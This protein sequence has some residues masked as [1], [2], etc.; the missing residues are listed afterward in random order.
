ME[1]NFKIK[2]PKANS[3]IGMY[4]DEPVGMDHPIF[5]VRFQSR[6]DA[7]FCIQDGVPLKDAIQITLARMRDLF[8]DD[9][10]DEL[11]RTAVSLEYAECA[12]LQPMQLHLGV[13]VRLYH[14]EGGKV[15][16]AEF[17]KI[18]KGM[19]KAKAILL[20]DEFLKAVKPPD[21]EECMEIIGFNGRIEINV[22]K[23]ND[24]E[25]SKAK[26]PRIY[27]DG[28][29]IVT[30]ASISANATKEDLIVK[31]TEIAIRT[32]RRACVVWSESETIYAEPAKWHAKE[33]NKEGKKYPHITIFGQKDC[34]L[35]YPNTTEEELIV[36]ATEM[37][38]T[39]C[40]AVCVVLSPTKSIYPRPPQLDVIW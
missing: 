9:F 25:M 39:W 24:N 32:G 8:G 19:E 26:Y 37:V 1:S 22:V 6:I 16:V 35:F 33:G 38:A 23:K 31:A 34:I 4:V 11:V 12:A 14:K 29:P 30:G 18:I 7:G 15:A 17:S 20:Q 28:P 3:V 21:I 36:K 13:L 10:P 5:M 27:V 40:P 2:N